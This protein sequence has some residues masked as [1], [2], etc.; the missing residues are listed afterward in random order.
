[1]DGKKKTNEQD[2]MTCGRG[3]D[4]INKK[5]CICSGLFF[6]SCRGS[7]FFHSFG[8]PFFFFF[9]SFFCSPSTHCSCIELF[10]MTEE[11]VEVKTEEKKEEEVKTETSL[12]ERMKLEESPIIS[13]FLFRTFHSKQEGVDYEQFWFV[14]VFSFV[15]IFIFVS[16]C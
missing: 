6:C 12:L 9:F 1:M 2:K 14:F 15:F 11:K 16:L 10:K 3:S 4:L 7:L 13:S 8:Y 5:V